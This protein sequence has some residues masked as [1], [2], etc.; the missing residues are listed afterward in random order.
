MKFPFLLLLALLPACA[1]QQQCL[2]VLQTDEKPEVFADSVNRA[3][4]IGRW[5]G[6]SKVKNGGP[7][8]KT[9]SERRADGTFVVQFR[10]EGGGKVREQVEAGLWGFSGGIYFTLTRAIKH[11][12]RFD[13]VDATDASFYDAYKALVISPSEFSYRSLSTGAEF[14]VKKV[15]EDFQ[16]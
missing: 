14:K 12:A 5:V 3:Q 8:V 16:L 2:P 13:P 1:S 4:L 7:T 9:L 15:G 6:E 11:G 10:M